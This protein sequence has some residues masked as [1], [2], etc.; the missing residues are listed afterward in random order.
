ML[1]N[2]LVKHRGVDKFLFYFYQK[3]KDISV[4]M[5]KFTAIISSI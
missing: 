1:I 2:E 4:I 3:V 5:N